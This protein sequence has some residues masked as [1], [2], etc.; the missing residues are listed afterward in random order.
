MDDPRAIL[1]S[2]VS[3]LR[4]VAGAFGI[5]QKQFKGVNRMSLARSASGKTQTIAKLRQ[6]H[7]AMLDAVLSYFRRAGMAGAGG[8]NEFADR[9]IMQT[10]S[11]YPRV[12]HGLCGTAN[13]GP[14]ELQLLIE[15]VL[16]PTA[17]AIIC[18]SSPGSGGR[19]IPSLGHEFD[20]PQSWYAPAD[21]R[22]FS[23]VWERWLRVTGF[24][25][26][27]GFSKDSGSM[28]DQGKRWL[29]GETL[30]SIEDIDRTV[31]R[32]A[33]RVAWLDEP[34]AW[35]ARLRLA[36]ALHHFRR[37]EEKANQL[38]GDRLPPTIHTQ[39]ST[40]EE[41]GILRDPDG[42]LT[43]PGIFFAVRLLQKRLRGEGSWDRATRPRRASIARHYSLQ[44]SDAKI[45]EVQEKDLRRIAPG[46]HLVRYLGRRGRIPL[47]P[48]FAPLPPP[49]RG[50]FEAYVAR[51]GVKEL[52]RLRDE[53][54]P[55]L[56][57]Q[58]P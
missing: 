44:V 55:A 27:C 45:A 54:R 14:R 29:A 43:S 37:A 36:R 1:T 39:F 30:P 15:E 28:R 42:W 12:C 25:T 23:A 19:M 41:E 17:W 38:T 7:A 49:S 21:G 3:I 13:P 16:V 56:K 53:R 8:A 46:Y 48:A 5:G 24:R 2:E 9:M 47:G 50:L 32:F 31:R 40:I 4:E 22:S 11:L 20:G 34:D 33:N 51:L 35:R 10:L 57:S 52:Q 6:V 26:P 18:E 58:P